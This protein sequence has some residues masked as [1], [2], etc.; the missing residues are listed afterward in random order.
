MG[1]MNWIKTQ[2]NNHYEEISHKALAILPYGEIGMEIK[3]ILNKCYG[4]HEKYIIDNGLA[5]YNE[6]ILSVDDFHTK[7]TEGLLFL[8]AINSKNIYDELVRE[9]KEK[10]GEQIEIIDVMGGNIIDM[11]N[12]AI[13]FASLREKLKKMRCTDGNLIRAGSMH[14]GGYIML[15]EF[16]ENMEAYSFGIGTDVLWDMFIAQK[17]IKVNMYDPTINELP[18]YHCNFHFRR[19]GLA[20]KD[21]IDEN[22]FSMETVLKQSGALGNK[23]LILKMDVEGAEWDFIRETNSEILDNFTQMTFEL[24]DILND[25][26]EKEVLALIDKI[27]MTHQ[28][29]WAHGNNGGYAEKAND[30][31]VPNL[32]EVTFLNKRNHKFAE[33]DA[34]YENEIL[35]LN[36]PNLTWWAR[37]FGRIL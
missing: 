35:Y 18:R 12:K 3:E 30:I 4:I 29:I 6:S 31:V 37:D 13:Y 15:D 17:G 9:L 24:H 1:Y 27:N 2:I 36:S 33:A 8:A 16:H 22:M 10:I 7:N 32:L 25:S 26:K 5:V 21:N 20:G 23:N 28:C 19:E 14:D 11:E 34:A